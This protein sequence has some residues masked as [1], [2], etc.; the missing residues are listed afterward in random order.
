MCVCVACACAPFTV[1]NLTAGCTHDWEQMGAA[2]VC[3]L[4][5]RVRRRGRGDEGG[6]RGGGGGACALV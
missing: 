3:V 5:E 2:G 1:S 4:Q 6:G